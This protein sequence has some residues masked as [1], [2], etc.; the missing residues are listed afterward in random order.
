MKIV[1]AMRKWEKILNVEISIQESTK[2][3]YFVHKILKD[4]HSRYI[5]FKILHDRLDTRQLLYKM[6]ILDSEQC[7]YRKMYTSVYNEPHFN[8]ISMCRITMG[9][10][11][12]WLRE[13][14][15]NTIKLSGKEKILGYRER[16]S[17][18]YLIV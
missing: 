14:V 1:D 15:E 13:N 11:E 12:I 18:T 7:I 5:Q 16:N 3:F 4:V 10:V 6:K 9:K 8:R 17:D 2:S